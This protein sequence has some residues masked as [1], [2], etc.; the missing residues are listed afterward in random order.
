MALVLV[1]PGVVTVCIV[2]RGISTL[3][4]TVVP[5]PVLM[6]GTVLHVHG[7]LIVLGMLIVPGVRVVVILSVSHGAS[8]CARVPVSSRPATP[9]LPVSINSETPAPASDRAPQERCPI[10]LD[11]P[12]TE[13]ALPQRER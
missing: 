12:T 1:V 4:G 11:P 2:A 9:G 7:G 10:L 5:L 8:P 3:P 6:A 13:S